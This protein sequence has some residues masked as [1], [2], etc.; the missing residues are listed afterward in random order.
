MKH[1]SPILILFLLFIILTNQAY[2]QDFQKWFCVEGKSF[3]NTTFEKNYNDEWSN[4]KN[5]LEF[6]LYSV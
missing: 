6:T 5:N 2:C 1:Y 4:Y 3:T